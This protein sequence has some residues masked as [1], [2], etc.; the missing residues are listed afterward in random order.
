MKGIRMSE[1]RSDKVYAP[2]EARARLTQSLPQW[3]LT[4]GQLART[5][6]TRKWPET[7]MLLN[8]IAYLAEQADHH[9]DITASYASLGV[10]LITHSAGGITDKDFDLA[11]K[12]EALAV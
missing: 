8:A 12:I 4:D 5:Y 10:R 2:D 6:K 9:P 7:V 3:T 1:K 11:E